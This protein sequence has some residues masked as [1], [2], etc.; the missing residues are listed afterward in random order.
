M[1]NLVIVAVMAALTGFYSLSPERSL[2]AEKTQEEREMAESMGIYRQAVI[3]YFT[4]HN[5]TNTS[6]GIETLKD[7]GMLPA[8]STLYTHSAT[9]I[10]ENYRDSAGVIYIYPSTL[11]PSNIVSPL[12]T[13]S[14][15]SL[16]VGVYRASDNSLYSPVDGSRITLASLGGVSIPDTAPVW[17]AASN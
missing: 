17:M 5:V 7:E 12:L 16:N 3:A 9:S 15:Y 2:M 4:A 13:L 8:W 6:V 14:R 10:W 1:W 11:P